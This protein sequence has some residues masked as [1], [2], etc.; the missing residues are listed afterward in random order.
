[1]WDGDV[2]SAYWEH[3]WAPVWHTLDLIGLVLAGSWLAAQLFFRSVVTG[4]PEAL[5]RGRKGSLALYAL[6]FILSLIAA[7]GESLVLGGLPAAGSWFSHL[8]RAY[9]VDAGWAGLIWLK[10][11]ALAGLFVSALFYR[12]AASLPSLLLFGLGSGVIL[13]GRGGVSSLFLSQLIHLAVILLLLGG[14]LGFLLFG[15]GFSHS[16]LIRQGMVKKTA[17][18]ITIMLLLLFLLG[19]SGAL[20]SIPV[21]PTFD[22]LLSTDYGF[23]LLIK[24]LIFLILISL[25]LWLRW[26]WMTWSRAEEGT[27]TKPPRR[28]SLLFGGQALLLGAALLFTGLMSATDPPEQPRPHHVKGEVKF[29][30]TF[31]P[32]EDGTYT[33]VTYVIQDWQRV[34]DATVYFDM[35]RTEDD[36]LVRGMYEY[37]CVDLELGMAAWREEMVKQGYMLSF[38]AEEK[39][40]HVYI[41]T[42]P[43]EPGEWQVRVHASKEEEGIDAY[44]DYELAVR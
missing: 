19:V 9:A 18:F 7:L 17:T 33:M 41:A 6:L 38:Q 4:W 29:H 26:E 1:M 36:V 25:S 22:D 23:K 32:G 37:I 44:W 31:S 15:Q 28:L 11:A 43:V 2:W 42:V 21:L 5:R 35:W 30:S 16:G 40:S 39:E 10:P 14:A 12:P 24:L 3:G 13:T 8:A 20:L 27:E 34:D